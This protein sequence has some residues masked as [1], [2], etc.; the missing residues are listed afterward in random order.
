MSSG[1]GL[2]V[3]E[4]PFKV[5]PEPLLMAWHPRLGAD[6]A[7]RWLRGLLQRVFGRLDW[8]PPSS[9]VPRSRKA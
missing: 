8:K 7:H 5:E 3:L 2:K 4:L 9:T 1:L 6:P